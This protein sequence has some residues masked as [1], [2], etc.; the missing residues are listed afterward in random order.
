[1]EKKAEPN[2]QQGNNNTSDEPIFTVVETV[3]QFPGGLSALTSYLQNNIQ[4][5]ETAKKDGI[6]G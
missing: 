3:P 2:I 1:M 4:Y 6:Q 5:P